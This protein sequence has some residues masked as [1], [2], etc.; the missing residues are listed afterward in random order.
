MT[1]ARK[2]VAPGARNLITDVPGL[3]IGQAE[4]RKLCTGVTVLLADSPVL[5]VADVR[6]GAPGTRETDALAP[7][8]L[9]VK[10]DAIVLS[11]GSAFGLEAASA[12]MTWLSTNG[13][14]FEIRPGAPRVPIVPAAV[15]FDLTIGEAFEASANPYPQLGREAV[16][17]A[18]REFALGCH[19]AGTGAV[20]G[21]Y[22]GGIGSASA[23]IDGGAT[24][25]A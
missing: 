9:G 16:A 5:T 2:S 10:A 14:G 24:V 22:K 4:N 8:T 20:A 21:A 6:G 12:V 13:R 17:A 19:G 18:G 15:L 7:A 23:M 25:G 3:R 1:R 11:G